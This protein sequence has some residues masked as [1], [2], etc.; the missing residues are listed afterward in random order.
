[1]L[2][3]RPANLSAAEWSEFD[4]DAAEWRIA[5]DKKA[6]HVRKATRAELEQMAIYRAL[7]VNPAP[8]GICKPIV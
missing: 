1:M 5:A 3:A 4:L 6:L 7:K 2:F 8:G